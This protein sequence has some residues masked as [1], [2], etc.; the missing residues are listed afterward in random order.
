MASYEVATGLVGVHDKSLTANTV[1]TVT[2]AD[3]IGEVEVT[4]VS[5]T[6]KIFFTVDGSTPT[7]GGADTF[8]LGAAAGASKTIRLRTKG[9]VFKL[10]SSGTPEYSLTKTRD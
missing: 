3:V 9:S 4:N 8:E 7:V 2:F 1:D 10:I 6:A 5:G